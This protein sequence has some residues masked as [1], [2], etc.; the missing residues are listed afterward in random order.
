MLRSEYFAICGCH[1]NHFQSST[2]KIQSP[3]ALFY[4]LESS[5]K[6]L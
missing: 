5:E 1:V 4:I 3:I 2:S 6:F